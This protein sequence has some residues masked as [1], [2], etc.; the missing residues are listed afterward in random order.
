MI[1]AKNHRRFTRIVTLPD[2][3]GMGLGMRTVAAVASLHRSEGLRVSVTS[4]HPSLI[5]HCR[6]SSLWKA[7]RVTKA[8]DRLR[9]RSR[10]AGYRNC[11][12]R[13]V[14]SFEYLGS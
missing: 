12:G 10:F 7:V 8:G 6:Q 4:S 11:A 3:Q 1:S 13:A 14:V 2:Y 9:D 5:R